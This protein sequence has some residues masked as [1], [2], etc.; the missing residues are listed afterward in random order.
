MRLS[1][2][3][4]GLSQ[5]VRRAYD[6]NAMDMHTLRFP[7]L[8]LVAITAL[9][10]SAYLHVE[11]TKLQERLVDLERQMNL[12]INA[13]AGA[14]GISDETRQRLS[15]LAAG[16]DSVVSSQD[17]LLT[18]AVA[19]ASPAVVS[20]VISKDMPKLEVQ[21][22]DPFGDSRRARF[23]VPVYRQVGTERLEV[24]AGTG[25]FVREDGYILTNR[26]V[27]SDPDALYTVLLSTGDQREAHVVYRD[28][29]NDL[30]ILKAEGA[31]YPT[32]PLGDSGDLKLG[33]TVMAIGNALGEYNN[34]VSVG[35][36]SGKDRTIEAFDEFGRI[37]EMSGVLQTDAAIN[38]GNSGG[39]LLDLQGRA[40]GIN[41]AVEQGANSIGFAIPGEVALHLVEEVL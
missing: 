11:N 15:A 34:S 40:I 12:L 28:A 36:V 14:P 26:H 6:M 25:F 32:I 18:K 13:L 4:R 8:A 22:V 38:R 30:A 23:R 37:E 10:G 29:E 31:G 39:P 3:R 41:V 24:G 20:I 7:L 17:E 27:V 35:I 2:L 9:V 1:D 21:Y 16:D 5:G 19:N 33:Q